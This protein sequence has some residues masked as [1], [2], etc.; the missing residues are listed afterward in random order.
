MKAWGTVLVVLAAIGCSTPTTPLPAGASVDSDR[1]MPV[2]DDPEL[3]RGF[4]IWGVVCAPCH[5][6]DGRGSGAIAD[7]LPS[8]PRDLTDVENLV[9]KSD[10]ERIRVIAEGI[11]GTTMIG[12][13][14][15]LIG[16][17]IEAV[18]RYIGFLTSAADEDGGLP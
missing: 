8:P 1:K 15:V 17:E 6:A 5:G 4:E 18:N 13:K 9:F 12:W 7:R 10:E 14:E 3:R 16:D 11:E 2:P